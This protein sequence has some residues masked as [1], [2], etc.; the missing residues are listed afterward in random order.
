VSIYYK[1]CEDIEELGDQFEDV[2][3]IQERLY[4][5]YKEQLYLDILEVSGKIVRRCNI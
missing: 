5:I 3:F 1:K 2:D 4:V